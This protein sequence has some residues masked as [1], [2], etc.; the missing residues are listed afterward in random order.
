[1]S[2]N[3]QAW[4]TVIVFDMSG[5]MSSLPNSVST[6][7]EFIESQ[8]T[9]P[10]EENTLSL[11]FFNDYLTEVFTNK[12]VKEVSP[13]K[14]GEYNPDGCTALLDAVGKTIT[15]FSE[16]SHV[17]MVI[18]TDGEE[19]SSTEYTPRKINKM[20]K[21]KKELGWKFKFL[22]TNQDSWKTG[23]DFGLDQ[24]D[25]M[26]YEYTQDGLSQLMKSVSDQ[27]SIAVSQPGF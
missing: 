7:N 2:Q 18:L 24:E 9:G 5:S 6:I 14:L 4:S 21:T 15:R 1:M 12:P 8:K 3:I 11:Y 20:I 13:I 16:E 10:I 22:A 23:K 25:C 26:N 27:V 19:N 17:F